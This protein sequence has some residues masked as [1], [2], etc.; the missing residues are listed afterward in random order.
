MGASSRCPRLYGLGRTRG[1]Q[2]EP[3]QRRASG[4]AHVPDGGLGHSRSGRSPTACLDL[5][6]PH[7]VHALL[8]AQ[9]IHVVTPNKKL[10]SGPLE[11]YQTV[12]RM[13]REGYIHFFYEVCEG[14]GE[15]MEQQGVRPL[16]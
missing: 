6:L 15:R 3:P 1:L 9:G 2:Q 12:R 5:P 7:V 10:G 4:W 11:Q 16:V 8:P 14:Q 13:Q